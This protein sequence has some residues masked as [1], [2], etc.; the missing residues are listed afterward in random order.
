MPSVPPARSDTPDA[1]RTLPFGVRAAASGVAV[2]LLLAAGCR[3]AGTGP[4]DVIITPETRAALALPEGLPTFPA[5]L[6]R[7]EERGA[8]AAERADELSGQWEGSWLVAGAGSPGA[9]RRG[10]LYRSLSGELAGALGSDGVLRALRDLEGGIRSAREADPE[11]LPDAHTDLLEAAAG[12]ASRARS[13]V[14]AGRDGAAV[15]SILE[16]ADRLRRLTPAGVAVDLVRRAEAAWAGVGSED[17]LGEEER[18][19]IG[20]LVR[21]AR[22]ALDEG[23]FPRAIHRGYYA[24]RLLGVELR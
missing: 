14:E 5:L 11:T 22:T 12:R 3:D 4:L 10:A 23:D 7:A 19:R 24:C 16:G 17:A 6:R 21:G 8:F 13:Q 15:R 2:A 1:G 18:R 9:E 20:R